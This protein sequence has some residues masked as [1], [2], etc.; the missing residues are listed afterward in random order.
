MPTL[1]IAETVAQKI[2]KLI[3]ER[4]VHVAA[5]SQIDSTLERVGAALANG[6]DRRG[7]PA[8]TAAKG[9]PL[10]RSRRRRKFAISAEATVLAFVKEHKN[11]KTKDIKKYWAD[12]GRGGTADNAL[13][14]LVK[15]KKLKRIPLQGEPGS[16]YTLP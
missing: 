2:Q 13:S 4:Q 7:S 11:P 5:I 10:K 8:S 9:P 14:K 15:E 12:E 3:G 1:K 6:V 16:R